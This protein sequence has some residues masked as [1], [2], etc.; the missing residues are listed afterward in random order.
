MLNHLVSKQQAAMMDDVDVFVA[1]KTTRF[2]FHIFTISS[3][4]PKFKEE[5]N[6]S[7]KMPDSCPVS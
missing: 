6:L 1:E 2:P 3:M 4:K 5:K 7:L